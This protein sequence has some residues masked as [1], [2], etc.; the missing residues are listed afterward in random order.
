MVCALATMPAEALLSDLMSDQ[1]VPARLSELKLVVGEELD[2]L[3][4]MEKEVWS[5]LANVTGQSADEL[6]HEVLTG[7][8]T[9]VAYVHKKTFLPA[10][11]KRVT[12][13]QPDDEEARPYLLSSA[14]ASA[15]R[16]PSRKRS[17]SSALMVEEDEE[18]DDEEED[19][20]TKGDDETLGDEVRDLFQELSEK[21]RELKNSTHT[22]SKDFVIQILGETRKMQATGKAVAGV[23]ASLRRGS[24]V[25]AWANDL[26][27]QLAKRYEFSA[28]GEKHAMRLARS[29]IH[30]MEF[31]YQ[32]YVLTPETEHAYDEEHLARYVPSEDLASCLADLKG[33]GY[34]RALEIRSLV[35]NAAEKM[36]SGVLV[37]IL[38]KTTEREK[39]HSC[40]WHCG[41][42]FL[43]TMFASS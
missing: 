13:A 29:W 31:L 12:R 19:E 17:A 3:E 1:C 34:K 37:F 16:H 40:A 10:E 5:I 20:A 14:V 26:C 8:R 4:R 42:D 18:E 2:E 35:P 7:A 38:S 27:M 25:E 9:A 23:R 41:K 15:G 43:E 36:C 33:T 39:K 22:A 21:Q 32:L 11:A 6:R 28:Y 30:R 24:A